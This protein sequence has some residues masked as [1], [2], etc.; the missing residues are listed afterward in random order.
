M[1]R[2][3]NGLD[4]IA[5]Q[6][7]HVE[8]SSD[9]IGLGRHAVGGDNRNRLDRRGTYRRRASYWSIRMS[10]PGQLDFDRLVWRAAVHEAGHIVADHLHGFYP[11]E[12]SIEAATEQLG[13]GRTDC[14]DRQ[15][16]IATVEKFVISCLAGPEAE[17]ALIADDHLTADGALGDLAKATRVLPS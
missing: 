5:F 3:E 4:S 9:D 15:A 1:R 16:V 17:R 8:Y 7:P 12:T 6:W 14:R 10:L 13:C 2:R 11:I